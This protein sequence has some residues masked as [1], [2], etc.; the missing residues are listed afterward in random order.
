MQGVRLGV[1]TRG[2]SGLSY[3]MDFVKPQDEVKFDTPVK[4]DGT[5]FRF[6]GSNR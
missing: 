1:K 6:L 2:C 3:T 4:Q 5:F